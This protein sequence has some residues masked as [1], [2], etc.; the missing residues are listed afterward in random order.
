MPKRQREIKLA[1]VA[2]Q[3]KSRKSQMLSYIHTYPTALSRLYYIREW[4]EA[5]QITH[6]DEADFGN[7]FVGVKFIV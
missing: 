7:H 3:L 5:D 4:N 2:L 1:A 6:S